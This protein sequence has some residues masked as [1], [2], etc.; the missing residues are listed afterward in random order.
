ML[1]GS[2]PVS[3]LLANDM[4]TIEERDTKLVGSEPVKELSLKERK[5]RDLMLPMDEGR[6]PEK[7]FEASESRDSL[8]REVSWEGSHPVKRLDER[9]RTERR[10]MPRRGPPGMCPVRELK[11]SWRRVRRERPMTEEGRDEEREL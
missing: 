9:S 1:G 5:V 11:F 3:W 8:E 7:E 6:G 10:V 4:A 2:Q